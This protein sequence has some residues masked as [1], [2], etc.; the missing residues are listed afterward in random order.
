MRC[1]LSRGKEKIEIISN[2]TSFCIMHIFSDNSSSFL[3]V[4]EAGICWQLILIFSCAR[5]LASTNEEKNNKFLF[6]VLK[7]NFSPILM[8]S[9]MRFERGFVRVVERFRLQ[10]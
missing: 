7:N 4:H 2:K 8:F 6:A 1:M 3:F 9:F 5:L 10:S